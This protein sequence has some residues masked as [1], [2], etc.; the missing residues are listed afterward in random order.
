MRF[1]FVSRMDEVL[2]LAL[3]QRPEP[4]ADGSTEDVDAGSGEAARERQVAAQRDAP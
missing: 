3:L 4:A 1:H 2:D